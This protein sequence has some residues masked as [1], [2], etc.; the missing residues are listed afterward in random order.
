MR[1]Y[2]QLT[3]LR[4]PEVLAGSR[5]S[6]SAAASLLDAQCPTLK[7]FTLETLLGAVCL[8]KGRHL[9]E[10]ESAR[11]LGV[12]IKHDL[13]F[14]DLT[15]L[16]EEAGDIVL[17]ETRVDTGHKQV[18]ASVSSPSLSRRAVVSTATLTV[19]H[20][21]SGI[22]GTTIIGALAGG[23]AVATKSTPAL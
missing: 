13:A 20:V 15:V 16:G 2:N 3:S 9:H 19:G 17:S 22:L 5:G 11:L 21:R 12:R 10:P 18:C 1:A 7:D 14:L 8:F 4:R 6:G 23:R